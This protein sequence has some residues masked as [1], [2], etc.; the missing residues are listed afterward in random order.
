MAARSDVELLEDL[1]AREQRLLSA[2]EGALRRDAIDPALGETLRDH[3]RE[4]VRAL[5]QT[6][7]GS[8]RRNPRASVPSAELTAALRD[9]DSFAEFAMRLE[10][11]T[12]ALC[13]EAAARMRDADLRRPLGSIMACGAAHVV[14][15]EDSV[16]SRFL[17]N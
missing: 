3:E 16:G 4:H 13:G 6:L 1:L 15:L 14:A 11:E 7:A 5:E 10:D 8:A 12:R 17:V 9:R 2:Y